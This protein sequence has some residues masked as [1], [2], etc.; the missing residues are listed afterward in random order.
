MGKSKGLIFEISAYLSYNPRRLNKKA[1]G[2][3]NVYFKWSKGK[4]FLISR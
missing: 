3:P 4:T 1:L 2:N